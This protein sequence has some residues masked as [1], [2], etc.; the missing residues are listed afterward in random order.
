MVHDI[1]RSV[2][3]PVMGVGGIMTYEDVVEFF[4]SGASAV[5]V[6]TANLVEHSSNAHIVDGL[7]KY[8]ADNNID[9]ISELTGGMIL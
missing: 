4:L 7:T 9:A 1:Y 6:G 2:K 8:C 3:I 5:Q